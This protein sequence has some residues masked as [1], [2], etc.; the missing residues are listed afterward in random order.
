LKSFPTR[1]VAGHR[2]AF[3]LI[4]LLVVI[5]IIAIL[6]GMLLPALAR[7]KD[8]T[9]QTACLSNLRQVG[10]ALRLY[11]DDNEGRFPD[12]RDLKN[13]LGYKPWTTWPT[14]DPRGGWAAIVLSNQLAN[15]AIWMCPAVDKSPVRTMV[16]SIQRSRTNDA[17]SSVSYWLWRFDRPDDP[18]PLDNFWGKSPERARGELIEANNPTAGKPESDSDV[19]MA[20]DPYFPDTIATLPAD[21]RGLA[22]H[23]G[24]RNRLMLDG[25]VEFTKDARLK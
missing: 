7:A 2:L 19:E 12:R 9:R 20:V 17:R 16:Q 6:A 1:P 10:L 3:T 18:V 5:A 13:R 25:H 11:V 15:D 14:S 24:G 8:R 21:V 23:R 22:V 4:E